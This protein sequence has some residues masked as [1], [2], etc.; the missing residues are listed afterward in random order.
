MA[1]GGFYLLALISLWLSY[2][3]LFGDYSGA[4]I[5]FDSALLFLR[6]LQAEVLKKSEKSFG[7]TTH[8]ADRTN[9]V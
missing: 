7:E 3:K 8:R 9:E 1:P 2:L 5:G 6:H 4:S